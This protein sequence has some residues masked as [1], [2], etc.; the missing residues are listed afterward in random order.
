MAES[1]QARV[2]AMACSAFTR[3]T[4]ITVFPEV[5]AAAAESTAAL[6]PHTARPTNQGRRP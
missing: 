2:A 4:Y 5:A 3:D 6:L 1:A